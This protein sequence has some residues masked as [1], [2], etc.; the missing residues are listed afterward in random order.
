LQKNAYPLSLN[1]G[2]EQKSERL[3]DLVTIKAYI[4]HS[5]DS[6]GETFDTVAIPADYPERAKQ[7]RESLIEDLTDHY[8][9]GEEYLGRGEILQDAI[10]AAVRKAILSMDFMGAIAGSA[11]KKKGVQMLLDAVVDFLLSPIDLPPT[12][13]FADD[14]TTIEIRSNDSEKITALGFKWMSSLDV[15]KL[16]F[17]RVSSGKTERARC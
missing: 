13:A 5:R 12:K 3:I 17:C 8:E 4:Y 11:F 14:G 2:A 10:R 7:Y 16:V 1:I 9:L 15:G 6:L